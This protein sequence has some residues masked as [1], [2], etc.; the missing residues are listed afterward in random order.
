VEQ[1]CGGLETCRTKIESLSFVRVG[2]PTPSS[3]ENIFATPSYT[4]WQQM[5]LASLM[6]SILELPGFSC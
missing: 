5:V 2:I 1:C 4:C 6:F 3:K